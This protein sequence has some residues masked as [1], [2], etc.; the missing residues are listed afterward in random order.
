MAEASGLCVIEVLVSVTKYFK[1]KYSGGES[2]S[3]IR[4]L[5]RET[6]AVMSDYRKSNG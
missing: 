4:N 6:E 3:T 5:Q 2:Q 1:Y